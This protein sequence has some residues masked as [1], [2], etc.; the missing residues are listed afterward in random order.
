MSTNLRTLANILLLAG[1]T[2]ALFA[3]EWKID[4]SVSL[5]TGYNDNITLRTNDEISSPEIV[6]SPSANFSVATPTSGAS[7]TL[8]FDFKRYTEESDLDDDNVRFLTETFHQME[9]S[10]IGL[11]LDFI[12]DTT[13]DSQL[14]DTGLVFDRVNRNSIIASPNWSYS[15]SPRTSVQTSYSYN[16]VDYDNT[17][18]TAFVNF[19]VNSGQLSLNRVLSERS[20]GSVT[21][22][23]TRSDNDNDVTSTNSGVQA[24]ADYRFSE[25]LFVS[26]FAGYRYTQV[27]FSQNSLIPIFSGPILIGFQPVSS[28]ISRSESGSTYSASITKGF[29]RGETS[30]SASRDI[31]NDIN[32]TP[33]EVNRLRSL[34]HYNFSATFSGDLNLEYYQSNV[35]DIGNSS[36]R[37]YFLVEPRLNWQ[38]QQ[39]WRLSGS[40]RYRQQTFD[41]SDEDAV[42]NAAYLTL[43]YLWP[44]IAISR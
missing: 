35:S 43:T 31:S 40:Y 9:R 21:L 28:D 7:G 34:N 38:F 39:F 4:P 11:D 1:C 33:I 19:T 18:D 24:G 13:L 36:N 29:E 30:L 41:N 8:R 6:L 26:A 44:K 23:R 3:A 20:T 10:R 2:P 17:A 32:G 5:R 22:S 12:K 16:R 27:D 14:E 25:T 15:F 42:Q 37:S